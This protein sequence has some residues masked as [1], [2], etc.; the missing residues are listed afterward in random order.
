MLRAITLREE[1]VAGSRQHYQLR[2]SALGSSQYFLL[3]VTEVTSCDQGEGLA[4]RDSIASMAE[5]LT[6]D[7]LGGISYETA[8]LG[9]NQA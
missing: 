4:G 7:L 8:L 3:K 2:I 9:E 5:I 1:K 6:D